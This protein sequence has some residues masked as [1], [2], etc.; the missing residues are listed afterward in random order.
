[1]GM[2]ASKAILVRHDG[3]VTEGSFTNIFVERDGILLTPPASLGLLP[4]ILREYLIQRPS[5]RGGIDA[6]RPVADGFQI[7]N[8]VRG[9]FAARLLV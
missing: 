5:A 3:L 9:L 6:R 2:G 4:G 1:M 8:A 7:G